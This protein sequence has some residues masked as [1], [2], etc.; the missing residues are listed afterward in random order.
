[1]VPCS[2][3]I[4]RH[5][6]KG[7]NTKIW[8]TFCFFL[9]FTEGSYICTNIIDKNMRNIYK[10]IHMSFLYTGYDI[11]PTIALHTFFFVEFVSDL[12]KLQLFFSF[13]LFASWWLIDLKLF[14]KRLLSYSLFWYIMPTR[15]SWKCWTSSFTFFSFLLSPLLSGKSS[16]E[17]NISVD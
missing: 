10:L 1:M 4:S 13:L 7:K 11:F 8:R 14:L 16:I 6:W 15:C 3:L 2:W 5:Q 9:Q 12:Y 17:W